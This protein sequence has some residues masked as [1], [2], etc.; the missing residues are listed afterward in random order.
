[1]LH[2]DRVQKVKDD[3]EDLFRSGGFYCSEAV[4]ASIRKNIAPEMPVELI[5]AASGFPVGV[6]RSKCMCGAVSGA[7]ISIGYLFG[8]HEPSSPADPKSQNCLRL[9]NELQESFRNNH[10]GVLC[11][12]VH[13]RGMDMAGGEHKNQ[14]V[15]FTGEMA[16]KTA[17]IALIELGGADGE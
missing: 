14:C 6:G 16:A 1:M 2:E 13:T 8:R 10:K 3:A 5:A 12:H 17:E 11:C 15:A 9:A 7:V 4:V